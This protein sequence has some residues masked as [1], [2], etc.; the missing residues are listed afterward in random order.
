MIGTAPDAAGI[1]PNGAGPEL[2]LE[3]R[4]LTR[5]FGGLV[6]VNNVDIALPRG[7]IL[8]VIGPTV[9]ARRPFF[10]WSPG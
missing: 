8:S 10:T 5:R 1:S 4:K 7:T 9:P 3:A 2:L 6:A